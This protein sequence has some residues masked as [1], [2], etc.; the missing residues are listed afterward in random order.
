MQIVHVITTCKEK[1]SSKS[2]FT[3]VFQLNKAFK[4]VAHLQKAFSMTLGSASPE[5]H[6]LYKW[7]IDYLLMKQYQRT[8]PTASYLL[9]TTLPKA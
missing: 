5:N 1:S 4:N 8:F 9:G 3:S 6:D 7:Q 2:L